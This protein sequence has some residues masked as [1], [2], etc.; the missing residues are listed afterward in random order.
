M[1]GRLVE[2]VRERKTMRLAEGDFHV[3]GRLPRLLAVMVEN[4]IQ[5]RW[6][7]CHGPAR[8]SCGRVESVSGTVPGTWRKTVNPASTSHEQPSQQPATK[9]SCGASMHENG[10]IFGQSSSE[11]HT[12]VE[13]RLEGEGGA[14]WTCTESKRPP[15]PPMNAT[16][17]LF[18]PWQLCPREIEIYHQI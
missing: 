3:P 15:L 13:S 4:L 11:T 8:Q 9:I 1:L 2:A 7:W 18:S 12:P 6:R 16:G 10:D 14:G 5:P 17:S